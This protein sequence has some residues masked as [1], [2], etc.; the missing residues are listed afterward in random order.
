[1]SELNS[2]ALAV[3]EKVKKLLALAANNANENEASAATAK[4]M[5]LL[6]A[7]NLDMAVIGRTA[8]GKQGERSDKKSKGGL[9]A[10]QR[11]IWH[12]VATLNFCMY[13][14]IRGTTRG[15]TYEHRLLGSVANVISA[16]VMADYLQQTV[17]RHAKQY[18]ASNG[19]SSPFVRDAIAYREGMSAR[20]VERLSRLREE[21]IREDE[22]KREEATRSQP[23]GSAGTALVLADVIKTEADYNND[24]LNGWEPGT[25]SNKRAEELA[26]RAAAKAEADRLINEKMKW[27]E[28]NPELAAAEDK[29]TEE[30]LRKQ[31]EEDRIWWDKYYKKQEQRERAKER[32]D[33]KRGGPTVHYRQETASEQRKRLR[34]FQDGA[35]KGND[36]SLSRQIDDGDEAAA[37]I[38]NNK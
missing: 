15:S 24:F 8:K 23:N 7:Y 13:W 16:E 19:F 33:A 14:S 38:G 21:R 22:H 28:D 18:A 30:R 32:R 36:V 17:E 37:L 5:D 27:R 20:I 12:A 26:R 31:S 34:S 9:Y 35:Q 25:T 4:A 2:E 29:E 10:W 3:I 11:N 6:A 1:M